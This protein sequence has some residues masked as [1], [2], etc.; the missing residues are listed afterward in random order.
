MALASTPADNPT[1]KSPI[2]TPT[3]HSASAPLQSST[4]KFSLEKTSVE[5][6]L[7]H[8]AKYRPATPLPPPSMRSATSDEDNS[9]CATT[10]GE[11]D[12]E[13]YRKGH[14]TVSDMYSGSEASPSGSGFPNAR[15]PFDVVRCVEVLLPTT[16]RKSSVV[17]NTGK[18]I[19]TET[20]DKEKSSAGRFDLQTNV[21]SGKETKGG[22]E[23][24]WHWMFR[25]RLSEPQCLKLHRGPVNALVLSEENASGS[26]TMY[27][28]DKD[29][30]IKVGCLQ[31]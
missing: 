24:A 15:D 28:V 5:K 30:F 23:L 11:E 19:M 18:N 22:E 20:V 16:L 12:D 7:E 4:V 1:L 17:S 31:S 14:M 13:S 25:Q 29:G 10:P 21:T 6:P 9:S 27:S 3:L 8:R 2:V 26:V